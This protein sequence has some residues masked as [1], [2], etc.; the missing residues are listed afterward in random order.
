MKPILAP[1]VPIADLV[2]KTF[3]EDVEVVL[4]DLSDPQ[5][6]VVYVAN[7]KVTGRQV[8]KAP[9]S[10]HEGDPFAGRIG[11]RQPELLLPPRGAPHPQLLLDHP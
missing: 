2:A 7:N 1:Y 9:S 5:H 11:R 8:E 6:S 10:D 4:H 3:G